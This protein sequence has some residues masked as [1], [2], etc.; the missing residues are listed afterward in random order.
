[1][2]REDATLTAAELREG[3]IAVLGVVKVEETDR[4]RP[5]LIAKLEAV[6]AEE[7]PDLPLVGI[8]RVRDA[9]GK[10]SYRRILLEYEYHGV[11]DTASLREIAD[12][13]RGE[14]RYVVVARV[15]SERLR[16]SIRDAPDADTVRIGRV[17]GT[18]VTGRNAR[19]SVRLYDLDSRTIRLD[20]QYAG[21]AESL[22]A[23]AV[24][25]V[26]PPVRQPEVS[27]GSVEILPREEGYPDPPELAEVVETPFRTF[28]RSL[29][30]DAP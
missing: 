15:E 3:R 19:V 2:L 5:P 21:T 30:K 14:A 24:S 9:M 10:A 11:I 23:G 12:S 25:D 16:R 1:M 17:F 29:P 26:R 6:L 7:R 20:A 22:S 13:L 18:L 28:V 4:V 8:Q 27:V